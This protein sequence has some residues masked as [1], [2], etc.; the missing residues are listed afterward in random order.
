VSP[1]QHDIIDLLR[2]RRRY[3]S[4]I[5]IR[6]TV[7]PGASVKVIHVAV[8]RMRAELGNRIDLSSTADGYR[9][10]RYDGPTRLAGVP[11]ASILAELR[12][13]GVGLVPA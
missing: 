8:S 11:I 2:G 3:T 12:E 5:E 4:A 13:R 6:D 1:Q 9:L 10:E 7:T